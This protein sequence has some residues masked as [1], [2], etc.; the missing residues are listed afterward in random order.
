MDAYLQYLNSLISNNKK[1]FNH[2]GTIPWVKPFNDGEWLNTRNM[3]LEELNGA[4]LFNNTKPYYNHISKGCLLCGSGGWS[5]L[6]ITGKCNAGCFYCPAPQTMDETPESQRIKFE[7]P[8][9]YAEYISY[10]GYKGVSFSGG[11]PLLFPER[12]I[13]YLKEVRKRCPQEIYTWLYTNGIQSNPQLFK[14]LSEAGLNE[15][16]FDIGATGMNLD[17]VANAFNI[18]E[19][20]TIEIPAVPE[21][22]ENLKRLLPK[23]VKIGVRNLNLHQMRLTIYNAPKLLQRAYTYIPA[24]Q[25]VVMES[26]LAALELMNYAKSNSIDIGINYCSFDFKHRFQKAGY[27]NRLAHALVQ[28]SETITRQGF[29]RNMDRESIEYH[30]YQLSDPCD[31]YTPYN[32]LSLTYKNYFVKLIASYHHHFSSLGEMEAVN[33]IIKDEPENI[34]ANEVLFTIWQHEYI[35]RNLREY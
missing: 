11:E 4:I 18:I 8:E 20:L 3:F 6:F 33:G 23:M 12:T 9:S 10:F 21:E 15:V 22:T 1:K 2:F 24:E 17:K 30:Y 16:R 25:P 19:N 29:L 7:T 28:G 14:K 26:E 34:P 13:K 35:E 27:R 5:C 32:N 31:T